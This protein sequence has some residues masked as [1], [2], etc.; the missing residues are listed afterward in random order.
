MTA[1]FCFVLSCVGRG[2]AMGR[3]PVQKVLSKYLKGFIV[4]KENS[5]LKEARGIKP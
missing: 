1:F 5:E 2:L 3:F 4:S